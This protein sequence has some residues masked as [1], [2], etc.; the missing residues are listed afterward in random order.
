MKE[1]IDDVKKNG[2]TPVPK[3]ITKK[4]EEM[5]VEIE[6]GGN[7]AP[8]DGDSVKSGSIPGTADNTMIELK[9][10]GDKRSLKKGLTSED[11]AFDDSN[12]G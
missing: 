12:A 11:A 2:F 8:D 9:A 5:A 6:V 3:L 4:E 1:K 10:T 7:G